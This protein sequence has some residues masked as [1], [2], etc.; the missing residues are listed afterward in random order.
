MQRAERLL[1]VVVIRVDHKERILDHAEAGQD[2]VSGAPGLAASLRHGIPLG[3]IVQFLIHISHGN[4]LLDAVADR[5]AERL[6]DVTA[7]DEHDLVESGLLRRVNRV[8]HD[9]LTAGTDLRK[10]LD[11]ASEPASHAGRH[12]NQCCF[13]NL[14]SALRRSSSASS[15]LL[16]SIRI[17]FHSRLCSCMHLRRPVYRFCSSTLSIMLRIAASSPR[18]STQLTAR[19]T[20]V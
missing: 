9:D 6:L 12:N 5:L 2:R 15:A 4:I 7:D 16:R 17:I 1:A 11:P 18:I 3:D 8:I 13:H 20:P 14:L 10:L 19:V